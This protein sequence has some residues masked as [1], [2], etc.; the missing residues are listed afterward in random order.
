MKMFLKRISGLALTEEA[1]RKYSEEEL[2][3]NRFNFI[4]FSST[5]FFTFCLFILGLHVAGRSQVP[6]IILYSFVPYLTYRHKFDLSRI[7]ITVSIVAQLILLYY[8][9]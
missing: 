9:L 8:F 4:I 2:A 1:T 7:L 5:Y 3:I 6:F